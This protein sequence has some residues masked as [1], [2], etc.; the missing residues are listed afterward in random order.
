MIANKMI[1]KSITTLVISISLISLLLSGCGSNVS[2]GSQSLFEV[3]RGDLEV[4]VSTDGSLNMPNNF[5]L[6]FGTMGTV[7]DILVK[8]GDKVK[9]GA[10]LAFLDNTTQINA[11]K[12]ALY[13]VRSAVNSLVSGTCGVL[14]DLP[15]SYPELSAPQIFEE[16]QKDLEAF[17]GYFNQGQYKDAGL[18][19]GMTYFDIQV[20][21]DLIKSRPDAKVYAGVKS[22]ANSIYYPDGT[23][24]MSKDISAIDARV[25]DYLEQY[26]A[27][28]RDISG[29][30]MKGA[31]EEIT[32]E[33]DILRQEAL[34]GHQ[35]VEN[36]VRLR[37][38]SYLT[39]PD[40]PTSL[41]FLQSSLRSLQELDKYAA[42]DGAKADEMT[43]KIYVAKLNLLVS[44]D[45]LE[46]DTVQYD[47]NSGFNW[48]TLQ[49]YNLAVQ[50]AEIA[51]YK[52]KRDIMNTVIIAPADGTVVSVNLKKD[53]VLS[54]Q[55]YSSRAAIQLVDTRTIRF[56]G[57]V[58][59]IDIMKVKVGQKARITVDAVPDKVFTGTV[60]FISPFGT[61]SGQVVKFAVTIELDPSDAEIRGGLSAT[62]DI[63]T[64]SAKDVLLVPTSAITTTPV[65]SMVMVKNEATGQTE[66]RKVTV[67]KQNLQFVEVL[68]GL[69]EGEK[70]L[71]GASQKPTGNSNPSSFSSR[72]PPGMGV[73]R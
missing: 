58:D 63:D 69:K 49:Q 6:A 15:N 17:I 26:R 5:N 36:T 60:K 43:R 35:L 3:K 48:K 50:S 59:E 7:Q 68:S 39:Y 37:G 57:L 31:Y 11:I 9:Q 8:E 66:P 61:K 30:M 52:T 27:R 32:T 19:L 33:L 64:Y 62:A 38:R 72:P 18:K 34:K 10:M 28:L 12:T 1:K 67:G 51:L 56:T 54:A 55:D 23:A 24:G 29:L 2:T 16:A 20:C 70:I 25:I 4:V 71:L 42:Q 47:L 45:V 44:R 21:E 46:N 65:G 73:L 40:V 14:S 22:Q 13:N 53:Y 41:D